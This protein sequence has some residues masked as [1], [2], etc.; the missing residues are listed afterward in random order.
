MK[1]FNVSSCG[2]A[3]L[4][5]GLYSYSANAKDHFLPGEIRASLSW[6]NISAMRDGVLRFG[7]SAGITLSRGIE[8]G[9][10]QQFIVPLSGMESR[11]WASVRFMPF[12]E[13]MI[14]PFLAARA[15]YYHFLKDRSALAAGAGGGFVIFMDD[16]FAFE[17]SLYTQWVRYPTAELERQ[18]DFDWRVIVFF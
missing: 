18:T 1:W 15:G 9:L 12:K 16:H 5:I 8:I 3:V 14:N 6:D 7:G 11:S 4:L 17:G 2:F 10:E 13:W